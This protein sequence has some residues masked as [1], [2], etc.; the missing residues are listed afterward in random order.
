MPLLLGDI[1]TH[2]NIMVQTC[3]PDIDGLMQKRRNSIANAI[4]IR[5]VGTFVISLPY[6]YGLVLQ[7]IH[8][9]RNSMQTATMVLNNTILHFICIYIYN[10][11]SIW[12]AITIP[13]FCSC[14]YFMCV[15]VHIHID[16]YIYT[17]S[18]RYLC[19]NCEIPNIHD[20][21]HDLLTK[22]SS[23]NS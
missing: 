20:M 13:W 17:H 16:I 5:C 7:V 1:V 3:R 9:F 22:I 2:V 15:H 6:V 4:D 18:K 8:V 21:R 14:L 12:T 11:N 23:K 10:E 19:S